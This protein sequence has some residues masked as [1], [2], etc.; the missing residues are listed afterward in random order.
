[1]A[2]K[3][4]LY[5][6]VPKSRN[7]Q[8]LQLPGEPDALAEVRLRAELKLLRSTASQMERIEVATRSLKPEEA[9]GIIVATAPTLRMKPLLKSRLLQVETFFIERGWHLPEW[10]RPTWLLE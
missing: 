3:E 9:A 7:P 5:P 10:E 2:K 6:H 8:P 1:M 4:P